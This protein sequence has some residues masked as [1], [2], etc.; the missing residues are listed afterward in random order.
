MGALNVNQEIN[1]E[2]HC[3]CVNLATLVSRHGK[4]KLIPYPSLP[5]KVIFSCK[6]F[7]VTLDSGANVSFITL[8]LAKALGL[9]IFPNGSL[10]QLADP[11]HRMVSLGEVDFTVTEGSTKH[12]QLR[13]RALVM[14]RLAVPCYGGQTFHNDNDLV[15]NISTSTI[16][17]HGGQFTFKIGPLGGPAPVPPLRLSLHDNTVPPKQQAA[18]TQAS[19]AAISASGGTV[20]MKAPKSLLPSGTYS[21]PVSGISTPSVLILPP[22]PRPDALGYQQWEPQICSV[23]AGAALY[24]NHSPVPLS[25]PKNTHFRLVPVTEADGGTSST[26]PPTASAASYTAHASTAPS[27]LSQIK[28]NTS[29]LSPE[30]LKDLDELHHANINAFNEDLRGGFDDK[31]NPYRATF[32]FRRENQPPPFKIWAPQFNS[33]CTSL[34]QAKCDQLEE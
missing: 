30:Q 24:V 3:P 16:T 23:A 25:H 8:A 4:P 20:L 7:V 33:K 18:R 2:K 22:T 21:I 26:P 15:P 14:P 28:V 12:V 32:S 9:Q 10:A 6:H 17:A 11:E 31:E 19:G 29:L 27:A 5:L 13:I 34:L 1:H